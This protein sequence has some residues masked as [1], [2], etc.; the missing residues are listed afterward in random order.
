MLGTTVSSRSLLLVDADDSGHEALARALERDDIRIERCADGGEA[1]TRLRAAEPDVLV[2]GPGRNGDG[3]LELLRRARA[4]RA[5]LKVIVTGDADAARVTEAIRARAYSY[6]HRPAAEAALADMVRRAIESNG[7]KDDIR[8]ISARPEWV[9]LSVRCRMEAAERTTQF[10]RELFAG[11]P[12]PAREDAAMAF[13]ELLL[14]GIEHGGQYN[15]KKR[16]RVS[17]LRTARALIVHIH[18][19]GHGFSTDLLP[20]AAIS[21]P[22][23]DPTR[24]VEIRAAAGQRPG[25]FG[26]LMSRS[27]VDELLYNERGNAVLFVKYL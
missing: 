19:P 8:P 3:G 2:A 21:N 4:I 13:R 15:P 20:N 25:G 26:I 5:N 23:G 18:D 16:V 24:H 10:L 17:M 6:F 14:N 11:A 1:L 9:T 22:D 27:L 12:A 7:W